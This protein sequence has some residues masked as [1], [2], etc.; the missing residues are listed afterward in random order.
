MGPHRRLPQQL[1]SEEATAVRF[2]NFF[3]CRLIGAALALA[4]AGFEPCPGSRTEG[5]AIRRGLNS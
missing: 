4:A 5:F 3:F 2:G 1:C